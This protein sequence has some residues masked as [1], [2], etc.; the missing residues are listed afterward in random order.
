MPN[1]G[2]TP[3]FGELALQGFLDGR[4]S[5]QQAVQF[6]AQQ[7]LREAQLRTAAEQFATQQRVEQQRLTLEGERVDISRTQAEAANKFRE[8]Q[9][10]QIDEQ[11]NKLRQD[12]AAYAALAN[13]VVPPALAAE[14]ITSMH[15]LIA[16]NIVEQVLS[17]LSA[18]KRAGI[19]AQSV[20]E[21]I[22]AAND[23]FA[24]GLFDPLERDA[25]RARAERDRAFVSGQTGGGS[26][27]RAE[28]DLRR[29]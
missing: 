13:T 25:K 8:A 19:N 22:K 5:Q 16:P 11:T 6:A 7:S 10:L 2:K 21:Q 20:R 18:E 1:F 12:A 3:V 23:R 28:D 17:N 26:L 14:G 9:T 4:A 27:L 15:Y 24:A 29:K